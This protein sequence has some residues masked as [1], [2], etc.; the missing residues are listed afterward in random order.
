MRELY[1]LVFSVSAVLI[2]VEV[3]SHL[4]PE[5]SGALV[6]ALAVLMIAASLLNGILHLDVDFSFGELTQS[7]E[8]DTEGT[9]ALYA[10]T[11]TTLLR[12][13]LYALLDGAGIAVKDGADGI[14]IWYNQDDSGA[15]EIERVRVCVTFSTDIDR[16]AA[17]LRS[18][19]TEAIR[20]DVFAA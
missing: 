20:T 6:H 18:V 11:G 7:V 9:A 4:F 3:L 19:L 8:T 16:A 15:V 5:K 14:E 13:R 1:A 12:K 17:L 2:A 10:E